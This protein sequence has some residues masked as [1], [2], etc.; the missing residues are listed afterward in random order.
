M[1]RAWNFSA[2]PA[3]LPEDVLKRAQA[4]LLEWDGAHASVME[5]SHRGKAFMDMAARVEADL[6]DLLGIPSNYKVLFLQGGA[7]QHFAQIPMNLAVDG[8]RADYVVNGHWGEKAAGEAALYAAPHVA[9]SSKGDGYRSIPDRAGWDLD[10][11]SAYVHV[12]T[13]ETIHGVEM[14]EIPDVDDAPLVA[15]MSSDILSHPLD[16]SKFGLIYA[17]AQKNIGPSGLVVMIV[18]E[19]LLERHPRPLPRIFRYADHAAADSM[20]NTPNTWG[21]YLAGLTFQWLKQQGGL[22]EMARRNR[23]KSD[24][25]YA[26]I[27]GSGGYY[28][29]RVAL[30]ARSRMNVIFNLR[31][32]ALEPAF[33]AEAAEAGLLALKGHRALGGIRASLYNA[34]PVEAARALCDFM[35]EFRRTHG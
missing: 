24:A 16:V 25:L 2:G 5:I 20:L 35:T 9:A 17:G 4:E 33:V 26:A 12:T 32:A 6:R 29:N 31:D 8:Q 18:R 11:R 22:A 21:W 13:N 34:V 28:T 30:A 7:T 3:A 10:P 14:R 15:D 23:V 19:D 27:D 1:S